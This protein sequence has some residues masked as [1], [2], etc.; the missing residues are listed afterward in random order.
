MRERKNEIKEKR[1]R[2]GTRK[3]RYMHG[4][5]E[6]RDRDKMVRKERERSER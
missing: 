4:I 1:A 2:T 5:G 6:R 3:R